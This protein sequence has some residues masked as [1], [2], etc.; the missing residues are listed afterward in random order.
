[1]PRR[2]AVRNR[3]PAAGEQLPAHRLAALAEVGIDGSVWLAEEGG[4]VAARVLATVPLA[5][6]QRAMREGLP[7]L[8]AAAGGAPVI[9]GAVLGRAEATPRLA[10]HDG[11]TVLSAERRLELRCGGAS[12]AITADGTVAITGT[13]VR[14]RARRLQ[15]I[16]GAQVKIN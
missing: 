3:L 14:S 5:D 15:R 2:T 11:A 4:P 12:V 6:L 9:L 8:V 1:M 16:T 10:G 7:V 13:D